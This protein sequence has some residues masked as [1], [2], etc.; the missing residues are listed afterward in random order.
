MR[1]F[2]NNLIY[3]VV[4]L[5]PF[6][7]LWSVLLT[8]CP[9]TIMALARS[10]LG[11]SRAPFIIPSFTGIM[12]FPVL[13]WNE[14]RLETIFWIP[15]ADSGIIVVGDDD[16]VPCPVMRGRPRR[17]PQ[18]Y[19][20]SR[21]LLPPLLFSVDKESYTNHTRHDMSH[22]DSPSRLW[23][24]PKRQY[25]QENSS[26]KGASAS[27]FVATT[28]TTTHGRSCSCSGSSF[29]ASF[30]VSS[31]LPSCTKSSTKPRQE[32]PDCIDSF[33]FHDAPSPILDA[34]ECSI[35]MPATNHDHQLFCHN[36]DCFK[37]DQVEQELQ[38]RT[39]RE[40]WNDSTSGDWLAILE[41]LPWPSDRGMEGISKSCTL[42]PR[43]L[44]DMMQCPLPIQEW[45]STHPL[46]NFLRGSNSLVSR[47]LG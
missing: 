5:W 10:I 37:N 36:E 32:Q 6:S 27:T 38:S 24:D 44:H 43:S 47:P 17:Q 12:Y 30:V 20:P 9:D 28:T 11:G 41:N 22:D 1:L 21:N 29:D 8:Y 23:D 25:H 26:H 15:S 34:T 18:Q 3:F 35:P 4:L 31:P 2:S 39:K 13:P 16:V 7:F 45:P 46:K 33:V 42:E 14:R 40:E 19:E